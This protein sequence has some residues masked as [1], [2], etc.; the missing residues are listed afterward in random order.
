LQSTDLGGENVQLNEEID[1][2]HAEK[3]A[4]K[5]ELSLVCVYVSV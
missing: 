3:E 5:E 4:L 1:M 2:L